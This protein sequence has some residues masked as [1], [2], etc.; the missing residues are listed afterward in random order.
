VVL[1]KK[2]ILKTVMTTTMA[3]VITAHA[4]SAQQK[5]NVTVLSG[6]TDQTA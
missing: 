5:I 2:L 3:T 1:T 6:Y 4:A